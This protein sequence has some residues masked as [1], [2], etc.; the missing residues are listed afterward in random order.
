MI[1]INIRGMLTREPDPFCEQSYA[2]IREK[3]DHALAGDD[4]IMLDIDSHGGDSIGVKALADYVFAHRDR[5]SAYVSGVCA[6]AAYYI[7][8]ACRRITAAED[9]IVGSVGTIGWPPDVGDAKVAT[10]SPLKNSGEDLQAILDDGCERFLRD[11]ARYR[12]FSGD[13]DEI[14][15]QVGAGAMLTAREALSRNLIDEVSNMDDEVNKTEL[16]VEGIAAMLPKLLEKIDQLAEKVDS[17]DERVG[18]L[19]QRLDELK[20]V[21]ENEAAAACED[22]ESKSEDVVDD[23][24]DDDKD[25]DEIMACVIDAAKAAGLIRAADETFARRLAMAS[26]ALFRDFLTSRPKASTSTAKLSMATKSHQ[27]V[28]KTRNERAKQIM[29]ATG[30]DYA[31][32]LA[33]CIEKE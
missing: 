13:L 4:E 9:A 28:A 19:E 17:A 5:I 21:D 30:C 27:P 11:I 2:E 22:D 6:S 10:L 18:L 23:V 14:A 3:L 31:T 26:P 8:A 12:N 15:K 33:Q 7:A 29:Q 1:R 25:K 32:A 20:K 24:V 16:D